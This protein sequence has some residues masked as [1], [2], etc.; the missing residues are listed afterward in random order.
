MARE[1]ISPKEKAAVLMI[2][3]GQERAAKIYKHLSEEEIEQLTLA[4]TTMRRVEPEVKESVVD[5]FFQM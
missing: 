1:K 3:I 5:E 2:T 4:I